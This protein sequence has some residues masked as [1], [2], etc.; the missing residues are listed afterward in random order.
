[1]VRRDYEWMAR[2]IGTRRHKDTLRRVAHLK[3]RST[4]LGKKGSQGFLL[5]LTAED[6]VPF[7]NPFR[8]ECSTLVMKGLMQKMTR[9]I[10][11]VLNNFDASL[12]WE[13]ESA[14]LVGL[15]WLDCGGGPIPESSG[16][17]GFD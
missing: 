15:H 5:A 12:S 10:G 1:V 4:T 9:R 11:T 13:K 17:G 6:L 16:T 3:L 2:R 7:A 14:Q 8:D